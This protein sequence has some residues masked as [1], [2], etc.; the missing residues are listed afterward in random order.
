MS[1][2]RSRVFIGSIGCETGYRKVYALRRV[3]LTSQIKPHYYPSVRAD[4]RGI[5][6]M[7]FCRRQW[8]LSEKCLGQVFVADRGRPSAATKACSIA[9][10]TILI[11]F[12]QRAASF[13]HTQ[14]ASDPSKMSSSFN[15]NTEKDE[16]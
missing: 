2:M 13:I 16:S 8:R 1:L 10:L 4:D 6:W 15:T 9:T 11:F 3:M 14:A 12:P 7:Y 5:Y